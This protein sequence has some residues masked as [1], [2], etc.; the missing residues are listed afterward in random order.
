MPPMVVART[1]VRTEE[2]IRWVTLGRPETSRLF[3]VRVQRYWNQWTLLRR[4]FRLGWVA[5][6]LMILLGGV[7]SGWLRGSRLL[8]IPLLLLL[9][10]VGYRV[11]RSRWPGDFH[12]YVSA[13]EDDF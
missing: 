9:G 13:K 2:Q 1:G 8:A 5:L 4:L 11:T 6:T 10:Y 7:L 3:D 12:A